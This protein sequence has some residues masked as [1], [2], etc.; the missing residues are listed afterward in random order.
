MRKFLIA[1]LP[2]EESARV[3]SMAFVLGLIG[4]AC[5]G[6]NGLFFGAVIGLIIGLETRI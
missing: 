4:C 3:L 2:S 6:W 5:F 1:I